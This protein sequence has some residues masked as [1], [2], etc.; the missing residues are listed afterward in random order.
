MQKSPKN[1]PSVH[2]CTTLSGDIFAIKAYIDNRK[3][4][5]VKQQYFHMSSQYGELQPANGWDWLVWGT[6]ANFNRFCILVWLLQQRRLLETNQTLHDALPSPG[7][8]HYICIFGGSCP[9]TEFCQV[10]NSLCVQILCSPILAALL[11][12]TRAVGN[13]QTLRRSADGTT[14][15]RQGSPHV[16]HWPTF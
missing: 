12:G 14:Y 3:K 6:P 15:I 1:S 11:H 7:L 13:S 2:Y 16:G 9:L 4:K 5:L 8:V 10:Q